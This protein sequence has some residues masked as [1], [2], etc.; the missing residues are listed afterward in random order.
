M[1]G[2]AALCFALALALGALEYA[3]RTSTAALTV[4]EYSQ[5]IGV[6]LFTVLLAVG[7]IALLRGLLKAPAGH[8]TPR[9]RA[10]TSAARPPLRDAS[11]L[12]P[13]MSITPEQHVS[14]GEAD[15]QAS[16]RT[17]AQALDLDQ[18]ARL[19]LDLEAAT[20]ITLHLEHLSPSHCKRAITSV[21]ALITAIPMPPRLKVVFNHCPKAGAPRH[22][23][24][25]G[26]LAQT[27]PRGHFRVVSHVDAVD[28]M[29]LQPDPVWSTTG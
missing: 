9:S 26:A 24:V 20:P 12:P 15:W 3:D 13:P 23:Q 17:L 4:V 10:A 5:R 22:H 8:H 14:S 6:P 1:K 21:G 25:A 29:F 27:M 11:T 2:F 28:V 19:T 7:V 18:G 16:V